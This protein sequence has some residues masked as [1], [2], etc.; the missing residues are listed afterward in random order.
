M[1][2]QFKLLDRRSTGQGSTIS[3]TDLS[4]TTRMIIRMTATGKHRYISPYSMNF[5]F[6]P[7]LTCSHVALTGSQNSSVH[8]R[9]KKPAAA[10]TAAISTKHT[11]RYPN[12]LCAASACRDARVA[13][14]GGEERA[15][16]GEG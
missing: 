14:R 15:F 9:S 3:F 13:Q 16:T 11:P 4:K 8:N 10:D 2:L 12:T 6:L 5:W 1:K 7:A